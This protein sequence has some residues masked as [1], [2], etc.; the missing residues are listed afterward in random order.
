[1]GIKPDNNHL[2]TGV[3]GEDIAVRFIESKGFAVI[4]RNYRK[5]YGEIDIVA[6]KGRTLHFIEVKTVSRETQNYYNKVSRETQEFRPE[7]NVTPN[8][9]KRL[10]RVIMAYLGEKIDSEW[11]FDVIAIEVSRETKKAKVRFL[12]DLLLG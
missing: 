12:Q 4:C 2:N 7:E 11:Q 6:K 10:G 5:T 9:I 8:K 1:M 3:L